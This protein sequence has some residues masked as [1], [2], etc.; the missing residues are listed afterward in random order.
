MPLSASARPQRSDDEEMADATYLDR[1]RRFLDEQS[2]DA[3]QTADEELRHKRAVLA[4]STVQPDPEDDALLRRMRVGEGGSKAACPCVH[5]P[6]IRSRAF[7]T[8]CPNRFAPPLPSSLLKAFLNAETHSLG[9]EADAVYASSR[10][11]SAS[12]L[13]ASTRAYAAGG[14]TTSLAEPS[15]IAD[16]IESFLRQSQGLGRGGAEPS[17]GT[18]CDHRPAPSSTLPAFDG[19]HQAPPLSTNNYRSERTR[20]FIREHRLWM[21]NVRGSMAQASARAVPA[22]R[23]G[24]SLATSAAPSGSLYRR[25]R[26]MHGAA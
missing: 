7:R 18:P 22:P 9:A 23:A 4:A 3:L 1:A 15:P 12:R 2:S 14:G 24:P 21:A 20:D 26:L 8:T 6:A 10:L 17:A 11:L 13:P 5:S 19:H 16:R 25:S